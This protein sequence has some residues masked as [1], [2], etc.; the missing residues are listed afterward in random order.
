[1]RRVLS[2]VVLAA[3]CAASADFQADPAALPT[4]DRRE[5]E[6]KSNLP[7]GLTWEEQERRLADVKGVFGPTSNADATGPGKATPAR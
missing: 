3:G 2:L 7:D 6:L 4:A 1:M 5:L